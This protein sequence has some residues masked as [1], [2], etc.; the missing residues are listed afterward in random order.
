[1]ARLW[2]EERVNFSGDYYTL[3]DATIAPKPVQSPL[4]LWVGGERVDGRRMLAA[5]LGITDDTRAGEG[6]HWAA[7]AE[8]G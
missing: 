4:P 7:W 2:S 3:D 5:A 8:E 6:P 1:M